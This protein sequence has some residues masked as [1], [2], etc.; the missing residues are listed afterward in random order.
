[1]LKLSE[2]IKVWDYLD[3]IVYLQ[4][5]YDSAKELNNKCSYQ[6]FSDRLGFDSTSYSFQ[7]LNG[8]R[9][10]APRTAKRISSA[11]KLN[12]DETSYFNALCQY[13]FPKNQKNKDEAM[14]TI[15]EIRQSKIPSDLDRAY[16]EYFS[17]WY[18]PVIRELASLPE[19]V[20]EPSWISA[21]IFPRITAEQAEHSLALL[22][23]INFIAFDPDLQRWRPTNQNIMT[24]DLVRSLVLKQFHQSII[25]VAQSA[26]TAL[27]A[28]D[29][30]VMAT[31]IAMNAED[32]ARAVNMLR[33]LHQEIIQ[34]ISHSP[35]QN[36]SEIFQLN[37]Q[38][39]AVSRSKI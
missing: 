35:V 33:K 20:A 29:R 18:H 9:P 34:S 10:L 26:V 14:A 30:E 1:V 7:V 21:K 36:G 15:I 8:Q 24:K 31:T 5:L 23:K 19:F 39:F 17:E 28:S 25:E 13:R 12:S 38:L 16:S 3:P 32:F 4:A 37:T 27:P 22:K 11:L 2:T 6:R